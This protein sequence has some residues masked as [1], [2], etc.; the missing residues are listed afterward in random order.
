[1]ERLNESRF[2]KRGNEKNQMGEAKRENE[3]DAR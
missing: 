2:E 3:M 1:M